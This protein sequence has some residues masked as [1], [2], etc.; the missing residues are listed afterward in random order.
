MFYFLLKLLNLFFSE[1]RMREFLLATITSQTADPLKI[2]PGL[3]SL[4][5]EVVQIAGVFLHLISHNRAVF[6]EY[7]FSIVEES[8]S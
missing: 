1:Q 2:P 4:Q 3:T 7:Y 8:L 6:Q 5:K